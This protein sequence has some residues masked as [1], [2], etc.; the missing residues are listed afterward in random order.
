MNWADVFVTAGATAGL[1]FIAFVLGQFALKLIVEP[2]QE[3]ARIVGEVTHVLT[4]YRNVSSDTSGFGP[5]G[6]AEARRKY[7]DLAAQLRKNL[8][9]LRLWYGVFARPPFVLPA[10]NVRKA[11][12]ALIILSTTVRKDHAAKDVQSNR[13]VVRESLNIE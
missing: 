9:V 4:Y 13:A 10:E 12:A 7:R 2:I 3:Q 5:E 11:A 1:G 8:R 6:I